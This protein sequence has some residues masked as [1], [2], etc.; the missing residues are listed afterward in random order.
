MK[1]IL[2]G[3]AF[4]TSLS[5]HGFIHKC[6]TYVSEVTKNRGGSQNRSLMKKKAHDLLVSE[7]RVKGY[8][9]VSKTV[10]ANII[11][12]NPVTGC[13]NKVGRTK[14]L[15]TFSTIDYSF[16]DRNSSVRTKKLK[17]SK[18]WKTKRNGIKV[19]KR[20]AFSGSSR[21]SLSGKATRMSA[22]SDA[23]DS[24]RNCK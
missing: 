11:F 17:G 23:I 24:I 18:V 10:I 19:I 16:T 4:F 9:I 7:L 3:L 8:R 13:S 1:K 15:K 2:I 22:V 6:D 5:S 14:C 21:Y 12:N 20:R